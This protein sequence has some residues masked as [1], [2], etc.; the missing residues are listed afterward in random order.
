VTGAIEESLR[1]RAPF[2]FF[3]RQA[4]CDTE[5]AGMPISEG[6]IVVVQIAAANRDP[7]QFADPER[8]D[9]T[10]DTPHLSLGHGI[11][12]CLGAHLGRMEARIALTALLPHLRRRAL[13]LDAVERIDTAF[14]YGYKA[15]ELVREGP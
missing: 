15:C 3:F 1:Y 6:D 7:R 14:I 4:V 9:I 5:I 13:R 11:H 10:R 8:F 2:Q 12:F